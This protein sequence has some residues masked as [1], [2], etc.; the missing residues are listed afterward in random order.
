MP[1]TLE[2]VL[3]KI[4]TVQ[5]KEN[6]QLLREFFQ[7]QKRS[8]TSVCYQRANIKALTAYALHLGKETRLLT[9]AARWRSLK[10]FQKVRTSLPSPKTRKSSLLVWTRN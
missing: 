6:V 1:M 8:E 2:T 7:F 9:T 3:A 4:N 5:N 10:D